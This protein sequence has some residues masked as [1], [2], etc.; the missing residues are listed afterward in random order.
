MHTE[1]A[2]TTQAPARRADSPTPGPRGKPAQLPV[3]A[4][5]GQGHLGSDEQDLPTAGGQGHS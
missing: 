1:G 2:A 5:I 3:V 4:L